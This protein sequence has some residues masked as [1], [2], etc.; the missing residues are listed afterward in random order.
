MWNPD[1]WQ[2][3][4]IGP[5]IGSAAAVVGVISWQMVRHSS[6][7]LSSRVILMLFVPSMDVEAAGEAMEVRTSSTTATT[8]PEEAIKGSQHPDAWK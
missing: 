2:S 6:S 7:N 3:R 4:S 1:T 8:A 5:N